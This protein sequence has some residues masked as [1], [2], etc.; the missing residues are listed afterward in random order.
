M[1]RV[2]IGSFLSIY[3]S[4]TPNAL[5]DQRTIFKE[6]QK[7]TVDGVFQVADGEDIHEKP[8]KY[9]SILLNETI[10]IVHEGGEDTDVTSMKLWLTKNQAPV[11]KSLLGQRIRATGIVKYYWSGPST[12]PNPAKFQLI[13]VVPITVKRAKRAEPK[14]VEPAIY[15]GVKYLAP[16]FKHNGDQFERGYIEAWDIQ[17][18]K[19]LWELQVYKLNYDKK[20]EQDVQD[21]FITSLTITDDK[22][23][24]TTERNDV[25]E[26]NLQSQKVRK[27]K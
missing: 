9:E 2:I 27:I 7:I 6:G 11:F 22:L 23:L 16:H 5:C 24:V 12:M 3:L 1:T 21:V 10:T 4:A 13:E 19:K 18:Q 26:V 17:S 8:I 25:Y 20:F 15:N 14:E